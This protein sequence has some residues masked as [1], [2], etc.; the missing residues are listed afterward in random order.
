MATS[1][2]L[3]LAFAAAHPATPLLVAP[4]TPATPAATF[5]M[6]G[7]PLLPLAASTLAMQQVIRS[8][9]QLQEIAAPVALLPD[10]LLAEVLAVSNYPSQ[11][12]RARD[13]MNANG[14]TSQARQLGWPQSVVILTQAPDF[15]RNLAAHRDW[16]LALNQSLRNQPSDLLRAV[17]MLRERAWNS[18]A[19]RD[20]QGM[21]V[22]RNAGVIRIEPED[23]AVVPIPS[24]SPSVV[25][26]EEAPA[27]AIT[28]VGSIPSASF[29]ER[30]DIDWNAG[31][32]V[33]GWG[34]WFQG[35]VG[36]DRGG[37]ISASGTT[38][39][40]GSRPGYD[41]TVWRPSGTVV[42]PGSVSTQGHPLEIT[43]WIPPVSPSA[44]L[45]PLPPVSGVQP[46]SPVRPATVRGP[47]QPAS[48]RGPVQPV[49]PVAPIPSNIPGVYAPV[50]FG[51]DPVAAGWANGGTIFA[52]GAAGW[53]T[54]SRGAT[55]TG[56]SR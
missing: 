38:F 16:L 42:F 46:L 24:Y 12:V 33:N 8:A 1:L 10:P 40:L 55:S 31:Q 30:I 21:R 3:I 28:M 9:E 45:N 4:N 15:L 56:W 26:A 17:Q 22:L 18:G 48:V 51:F 23:P 27:G 7:S 19:L 49:R 2:L 35:E 5:S 14:L 52:P 36:R 50:P 47:V 11:V 43:P 44:P 41:G 34:G 53:N 20:V 37:N 39:V 54:G 6:A 25:F 32:L 13:F 29:G